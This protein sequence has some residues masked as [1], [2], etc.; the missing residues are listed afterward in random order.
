MN[1]PQSTLC[2]P[3]KKGTLCCIYDS[4][5]S[6]NLYIYIPLINMLKLDDSS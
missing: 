2:Y 5:S 1:E 6:F 4:G 3:K